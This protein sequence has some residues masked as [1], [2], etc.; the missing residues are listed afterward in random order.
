MPA[1]STRTFIPKPDDP[2][3]IEAVASAVI[4]GEPIS[5][6]AYLAGLGE[7]TVRDWLHRGEALLASAPPEIDPAELGS[8]AVFTWAVKCA[9]AQFVRENLEYVRR[10]REVPGKGWLPAM[11]LLERRRPQ[12]FG[13]R[14]RLDVT[15]QSVSITISLPIE[16]AQSLLAHLAPLTALPPPQLSG[17]SPIGASRTLP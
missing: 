1:L 8:H 3:I 2:D 4:R 5:T 6:A 7:Q 16:A 11:T 13:R 14:D 10:D 17:P 12:D 15:Q 9:E